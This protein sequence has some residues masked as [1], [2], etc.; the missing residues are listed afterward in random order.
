MMKALKEKLD[1]L[2]KFQERFVAR[3]NI[4]YRLS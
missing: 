2:E 3:D 1:P 4:L